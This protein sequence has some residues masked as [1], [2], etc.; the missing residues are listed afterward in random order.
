MAGLIR[1]RQHRGVD[2]DH[3]LVP[4]AGGA[5]IEFVMEGRLGQERQR[6]RLMLGQARGV[7]LDKALGAR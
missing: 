7:G 3:N 5:G 2:V 4:L 6:V 1:V